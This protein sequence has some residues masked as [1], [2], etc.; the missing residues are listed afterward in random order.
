MI[1][2]ISGTNR[3]NSK[4]KLIADYVYQQIAQSGSPAALLDLVDL[5]VPLLQADMYT[6]NGQHPMISK[7]QSEYIEQ[8]QLLVIISPEYNGSFPGILKLFIDAVS[9]KA[10]KTTFGGKKAALIG[11]A[12]GRAGNFRGMEHLTGIL[13]YLN[14]TVMPN[15]LPV[16]SVSTFIQDNQVSAELAKTL[17]AFVEELIAFVDV[18]RGV[19]EAM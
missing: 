18:K 13:N 16:S 14:I 6:P 5:N 17:D 4:T 10:Y 3:P 15:K 12:S 19:L 9:A 7:L 1:T 2:I 11:V 8:A